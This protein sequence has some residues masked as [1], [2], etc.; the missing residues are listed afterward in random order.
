[1]I[2]QFNDDKTLLGIFAIV[3]FSIFVLIAAWHVYIFF[4]ARKE[5]KKAGNKTIKCQQWINEL[6]I[7]TQCNVWFHFLQLLLG[8]MEKAKQEFS[9][10]AARQMAAHPELVAQGARAVV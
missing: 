4:A 8:G 1:M 9:E 7:W 6:Y 10:E 5:Y 3:S 2:S